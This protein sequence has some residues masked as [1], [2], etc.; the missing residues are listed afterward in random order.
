VKKNGLRTHVHGIAV[1]E[2]SASAE[3][4]IG[5]LLGTAAAE[6]GVGPPALELID[7]TDEFLG[8]GYGIPTPAMLEALALFAGN[9]GLVLDPVYTGKAA[10][11]LIAMVR[12][13]DI[14]ASERV[15]FLHTG[16]GPALFAYG[17][18]LLAGRPIDD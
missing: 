15:L 14:P 3:A 1:L 8:D 9:E 6:L 16:G 4:R 17:D 5:P 10:A 7:V 2:D 13:G 12:R 18:A 11:G